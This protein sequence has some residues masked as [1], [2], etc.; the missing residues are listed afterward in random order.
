[1]CLSLPV[2]V[3]AGSLPSGISSGFP[4]KVVS[5]YFTRLLVVLAVIGDVV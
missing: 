2:L 4:E 3:D 5:R 1:M